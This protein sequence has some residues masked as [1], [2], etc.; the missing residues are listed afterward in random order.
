[1]P[2][3]EASTFS[4]LTF[5]LVRLQQQVGTGVDLTKYDTST[6]I[7]SLGR[8]QSCLPAKCTATHMLQGCRHLK[9]LG[10]VV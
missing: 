4:M 1:M 7:P 10:R 3:K 2:N 8:S 5:E 9:A 6:Y